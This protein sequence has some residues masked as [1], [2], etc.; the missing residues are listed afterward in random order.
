M[1]THKTVDNQMQAAQTELYIGNEWLLHHTLHST[2]T[3]SGVTE[4]R[5]PSLLQLNSVLL[6]GRG[7][8]TV[9]GEWASPRAA[10]RCERC[11]R[12]TKSVMSREGG[13]PSG[14][15]GWRENMNLQRTQLMNLLWK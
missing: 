12:E 2:C 9:Q 3:L 15:R 13:G 6:P 5:P 7:G 14:W 1:V 11:S 10:R 8:E 4:Q